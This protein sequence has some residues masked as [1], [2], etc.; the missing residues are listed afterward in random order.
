MALVLPSHFGLVR[1]T[2]PPRPRTHCGLCFHH[3]VVSQL[4]TSRLRDVHISKS[5]D[6]RSL[7]HL[8]FDYL[9]VERRTRDYVME[10]YEDAIVS[11][12]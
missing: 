4:E 11:V 6:D 8:E 5:E 7:V 1:K 9:N 3:Q 12:T 10:S 2:R